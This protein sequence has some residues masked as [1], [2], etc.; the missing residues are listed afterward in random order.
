MPLSKDRQLEY[1]RQ[2]RLK[3]RTC[4]G[5][6]VA[7][8]EGHHQAAPGLRTIAVCAPC[9]TWLV[10]RSASDPGTV[11]NARHQEPEVPE[12]HGP[13]RCRGLLPD[14]R[15]RPLG[16]AMDPPDQWTPLKEGF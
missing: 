9:R 1:Q 12:T 11:E 7:S 5:C 2:R 8:A 14:L 16:Q 15:R 4:E 13:G 10:S 3:D 6:G